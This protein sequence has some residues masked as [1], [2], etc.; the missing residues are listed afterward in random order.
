[1]NWRTAS[2]QEKF[3]FLRRYHLDK[4][5]PISTLANDLGV[6]RDTLAPWM[7]KHR[8]A[9]VSRLPYAK[10][11]RPQ[12]MAPEKEQLI[13]EL[14]HQKCPIKDI[15]RRLGCHINTVT[16]VRERLGLPPRY[17]TKESF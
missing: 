6:P 13:A 4:R 7:S 15:A 12:R 16:N 2:M 17:N 5:I 10:G 3:D 9:I 8:K 11:R 14:W 1:M